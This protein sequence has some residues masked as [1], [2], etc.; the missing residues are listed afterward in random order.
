M[1]GLTEL[2]LA[3]ARGGLGQKKFSA[4]EL[5]VAHIEATEKAR[6]LNAFI[7][8]TP[9]KALVMAAQSDAR[10]AKGD[11]GP[12]EGIPLG[13]KDLYCTEGVQTTAGSRILQGFVPPYE[14]TVTANLW[15]DGA[16]MLGKLNLDEFAMG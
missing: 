13:I 9:E 7:V 6:A 5:A 14:S 2:T 15:R 10:I 1:T 12:L 3:E 16:V 11:A 4:R 8:E